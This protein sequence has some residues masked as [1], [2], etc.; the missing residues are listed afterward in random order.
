MT[1]KTVIGTLQ[2]LSQFHGL[3]ALNKNL[4]GL[5]TLIEDELIDFEEEL[6]QVLMG[7]AL[8]QK[9]ARHLIQLGGKRLRPLC[10]LLA[11]HIASADKVVARQLGIAVELIHNAT[12]LHDDVIDLAEKR[13]GAPTVRTFYGNALSIFAGDWLLIEALRRVEQTKISGM[14]SQ[15]FSVIEQMIFAES[16]Q[17]ESRAKIEVNRERYFRV[18]EGK[19]A[20]LFQFALLAG[21]SAGKLK[22]E[23]CLALAEYGR[24]L[25]IAFQ[26]IDDLLDFSGDTAQLGKEVFTDLH[27]GKMTF[28]LLVA[29]ER[30]PDLKVRLQKYIDA[31]EQI[32]FFSEI[33]HTTKEAVEQFGGLIE[34]RKLAMEHIE[35]AQHCLLSVPQSAATTALS[36]VAKETIARNR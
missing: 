18:I 14:L 28:P 36:W 12:L 35:K 10:V 8:V 16:L 31:K 7:T 4:A 34:C 20:S 17:L 29:C 3:E 9:G 13:R 5:K 32:E 27:E 33:E 25:G 21:S 23:E 2:G 1:T 19:T 24:H 6:A 11:A 15:L 26:L 30:Y 22:E